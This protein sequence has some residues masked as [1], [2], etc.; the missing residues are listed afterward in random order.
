[1]DNSL[2]LERGDI[3]REVA[4][5]LW[6]LRILK[7]GAGENDIAVGGL[8]LGLRYDQLSF[9]SM[10]PCRA[11]LS[12]PVFKSM[13]VVEG[14]LG[15]KEKRRTSI[16]PASDRANFLSVCAFCPRDSTA[17]MRE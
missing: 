1:M 14:I 13:F 15:G 5:S 12:V 6:V 11:T 3:H 9:D 4:E 7:T 16:V 10:H 17:R 8:R 2:L